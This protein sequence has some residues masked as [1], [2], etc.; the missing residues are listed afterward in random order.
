MAS[1]DVLTGISVNGGGGNS[2][3][4][5]DAKHTSR[6]ETVARQMASGMGSLMLEGRVGDCCGEEEVCNLLLQYTKL[7]AFKAEGRLEPKN[8]SSAQHDL[9]CCQS[10]LHVSR[11]LLSPATVC[12]NCI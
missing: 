5:W 3:S 2:A 6:L 8:P 12:T 7:S 9:R 11:R 4:S 10:V 1:T